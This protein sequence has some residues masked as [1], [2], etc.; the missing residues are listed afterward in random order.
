MYDDDD[1]DFDESGTVP[2]KKEVCRDDN[3]A[4][5]RQIS[6]SVDSDNNNHRSRLS[7]S[8][9]CDMSTSWRDPEA[10]PVVAR[11]CRIIPVESSSE[12]ARDGRLSVGQ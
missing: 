6:R 8:V 3:G 7:L 2:S 11:L 10:G 12:A 1:E 9:A 5:T 4:N